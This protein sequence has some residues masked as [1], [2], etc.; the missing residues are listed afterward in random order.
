MTLIVCTGV[1]GVGSEFLQGVLPNGRDFDVYDI[2]ANIVGSLIAVTGCSFYHKRMLERKRAKRGYGAVA[3][4]EEGEE[5]IEL[6]Q[7]T[8]IA[9]GGEQESGI[10][11]PTTVPVILPAAKLEAELDNWDENEA[12]EWDDDG[13]DGE[14]GT[15]KVT[16]SVSSAGEEVKVDQRKRLD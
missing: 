1:L 10:V 8:G 5:D 3:Q 16:P 14:I 13:Q 4:G 15:A 9:E 11:V 12:D 7:G 2:A 6:G